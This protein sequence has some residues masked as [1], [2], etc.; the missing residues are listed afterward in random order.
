MLIF[1]FADT[2]PSHASV[3]CTILLLIRRLHDLGR[4]GWFWL[5]IW[6]PFLSSILPYWF[7]R[8]VSKGRQDRIVLAQIRWL[9]ADA[10][11]FL[12]AYFAVDVMGVV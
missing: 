5:L 7:M 6:F 3:C 11:I 2:R 8:F 1:L 4:T 12:L 10:F 9:E